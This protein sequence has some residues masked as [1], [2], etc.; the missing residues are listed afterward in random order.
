MKINEEIYVV[1]NNDG[2][3][4]DDGFA[5]RYLYE[6][7]EDADFMARSE[8]EIS[9]PPEGWHVVKVKIVPVNNS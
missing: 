9:D 7:K 4:A 6:D 2:E 5:E 3:I 1:V 8:T